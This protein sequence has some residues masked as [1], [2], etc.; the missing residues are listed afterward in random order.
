MIS[1]RLYLP[2]NKAISFEPIGGKLRHDLA[3]ALCGT[4]PLHGMLTIDWKINPIQEPRPRPGET[5]YDVA[6][7]LK[8]TSGAGESW[9]GAACEAAKCLKRLRSIGLLNFTKF[10]I[11][12]S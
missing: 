2:N 6:S 3:A 7:N 9:L 12:Q 1:I 8:F 4:P 10:R 5:K 11:M